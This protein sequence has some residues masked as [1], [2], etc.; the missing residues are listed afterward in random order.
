MKILVVEDEKDIRENL[1]KGLKL[2]GYVVDSASDGEVAFTKIW[3]NVYDLVILD[4]NIPKMDGFELLAQV[5]KANKELK[6]LILSAYDD[7]VSKIKGFDLGTNDYLTKPFHFEELLARVRALTMRNFTQEKSE[8]EHNNLLIDLKSRTVKNQNSR[9][10]LTSK[11][12]A[13][14][15]Y[16]V[17]N[18][19]RV[20]SQTE[21]I[22]HVWSEDSDLF[23]G[24]IRVHV[25]S[26]RKKLKSTI[27]YD[28]I[29]TK[30]GEG[31][32][33]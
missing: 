29:T 10:E 21:I 28:Y 3:E 5:R 25:S 6:V 16:L 17:I 31:Y 14:L 30:I 18:R 24:A 20:V 7:I 19:G 8:I 27:G 22:E 33:V 12:F 1:C 9:I 13:I 2:K 4:I 15:E 26:L 32:M 23:G 11:E